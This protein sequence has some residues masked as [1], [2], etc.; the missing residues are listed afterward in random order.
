MPTYKRAW[1]LFYQFMSSI[2]HDSSNSCFPVSPSV[3]ALFIAYLYDKQYAP[4][5]VN[6][7]VSALGYSHKLAGLPDPTKVFYILQMLKG[8]NKKGFRL[9]NRLPVTLPILTR[10][11][12]TNITSSYYECCL[13]RAMCAVAFFAFL[14]IGEIT[15]NG[16]NSSNPPL[17]F[18]QVSKLCNSSFTE[19][20]KISFGDYKHNYNQRPFSITMNRQACGPCPV[21]CILEYLEQGN[22]LPGPFFQLRNGQAVPRSIFVTFLSSAIR[23][24]G[25]NPAQY[26]GHSFRIGAASHAAAIG[27][28]DSQIRVLG[29]WKSNAF[30]KYI[31]I[32]SFSAK[33]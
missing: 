6:T 21:Q 16:K 14:R 12:S 23:Q 13:F 33:P 22:H 25:L 20:I 9:D 8:Y 24:C 32:D 19:A 29:R 15:V 1:S 3:L 5:T 26:K 7:Y 2:L 10:I 4:S 27:L 18:N 30:R 28:T 17:Q 31:R 11:L